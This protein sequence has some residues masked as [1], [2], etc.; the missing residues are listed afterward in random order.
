MRA[1]QQ[2]L[3]ALNRLAKVVHKKAAGRDNAAGHLDLK[4]RER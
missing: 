4:I 3:R 2:D 1:F